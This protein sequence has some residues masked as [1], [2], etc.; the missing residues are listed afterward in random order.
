MSTLKQK[1]QS[2]LR[3]IHYDKTAD[4]LYTI[5][6]ASTGC[7]LVLIGTEEVEDA[8]LMGK[9]VKF[10]FSNTG[11]IPAFTEMPIDASTK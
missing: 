9:P 3:V 1:A 8:Y 10:V 5:I 7:Y 4:N 2:I 6:T 11:I